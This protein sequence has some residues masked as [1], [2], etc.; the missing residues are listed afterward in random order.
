MIRLLAALLV[1]LAAPARA[2]LPVAPP[3]VPGTITVSGEGLVSVAPDR[4]VL[5]LGVTTRAETAAEALR[6]HEADVARVLT[7][8]R[9]FGIADRQIQIEALQVRENYGQNG[10]DGVVA[11]RVVTVTTDSLRTIPDLVAAVV[12]EGAN[13]LDGLTYTLRDARHAEARALDA[14]VADAAVADARTKAERIASASGVTLGRVVA[15]QEASAAMP[16]PSGR[17]MSLASVD[18]APE[19]GAYSAGSSEVRARVVVQFEITP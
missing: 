6:A 5:R 16:Y 3:P 10:L 12:S 18:V 2:Q 1:L 11:V 8:V 15:V 19:P 7:R 14:A 17:F 13:R 4:A 9:Q